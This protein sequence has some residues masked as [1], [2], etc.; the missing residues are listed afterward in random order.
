M[1]VTVSCQYLS[2]WQGDSLTDLHD[3]TFGDIVEVLPTERAL[4][5]GVAGQEG[6]VDGIARNPDD[7]IHSY[8]VFCDALGEGV[9][10]LRSDLRWTGERR[11]QVDRSSGYSLRVSTEGELRGIRGPYIDEPWSQ[12]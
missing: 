5:A 1:G 7:S 6:V 9:T 4:A 8:G 12:N 10:L 2:R 3:L 11:T